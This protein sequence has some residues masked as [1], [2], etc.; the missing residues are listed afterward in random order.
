MNRYRQLVCMV[1]L[2]CSTAVAAERQHLVRELRPAGYWPADEGAGQV[3]HDRSG[4]E[5]HGDLRNLA[6]RNGLLDFAN[7]HCQW[8]M[9]PHHERYGSRTFTVGGWVYSRRTYRSSRVHL[10]GQPLGPRGDGLRWS[11]WGGRIEPVGILLAFGKADGESGGGLVEVASGG[12]GDVLGSGAAKVAMAIGEWQHVLYAYDEAGTGRLYVNG[13]LVQTREGVPFQPAATPWVIGGDLNVWWPWPPDGRGLDG[14]VRDMVFFDRA[15]SPAEV[16]CL[17]GAGAPPVVPTDFPEDAIV[18]DRREISLDAL[19]HAPVEDQRRAFEQLAGRNADR[20]QPMADALVPLLVQAL[21]G[22]RTRLPAARTLAK[23]APE[24]ARVE[25]LVRVL[26]DATRS[27]TERAETALALAALGDRAREAIPALLATLEITDR[28]GSYPPRIEDLLRNAALRALLDIAPDDDPVRPVL[29]AALARPFLD[30][31][32]LDKP[33]LAEVKE[34]VAAGRPLDALDAYRSHRQPIP[35]LPGHRYWGY[36]CAETVREHLP[37]RAEYFDNYL[38]KGNPFS[39]GLYAG[40]GFR[41]ADY[42]PIELFEGDAYLTT[43]ERLSFAEVE[44]EFEGTLKD[45]TDRTPD[46]E[47]KWSRVNLLHIR[48]DGSEQMVTLEGDWFIFDGRDAK[49]DGW[50]IGADRDGYLHLVGGMHNAARVSDW[51]PGSWEKLG[52]TAEARPSALYWVSRNPGDI[53]SF[54]FAG[55]RDDPRAIPC[56]NMNY[57]N[58]ARSPD[59]TLFLYGRDH[60]WTWGLYRYDTAARRWTGLGGSTSVMIQQARESDLPWIR[61]LEGMNPHYGP[62]TIPVLVGAWQPGAYNFNRSSWGIRF[63]RTGRMHVQMGIWGPTE[64]GRLTGGPV[65]AYSDDQGDSFHRA[66]GTPLRLPLT[67]NPIP[68]HHA[69]MDYHSTRQWFNLWTSLV[70]HAGH[71]TP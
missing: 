39:D 28:D 51:V 27:Q 60:T 34:L 68:G 46:P 33:H 29:G 31:L 2:V 57:M 20:L 55:Q 37:V 21:A 65:Y 25:L 42:T 24:R 26:A 36:A 69:D 67:V 12:K 17:Y 4:N 50:A 5:N 8:A 43:V 10:F 35:K 32:D 63:D 44:R 56:G 23:V 64:G 40:A 9:I 14:S 71:P 15:L 41:P 16:Q 11:G 7:D 18:L 19:P 61:P 59:G 30:L 13:R 1:L 49:I 45:L 58:F 38:S 54:E 48:P 66:D 53:T 3:L 22:E 62:A 6:W 52:I 47:G 70:R